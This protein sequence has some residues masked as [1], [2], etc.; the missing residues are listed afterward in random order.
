MRQHPVIGERIVSPLH[1][2]TSL[3]QVIRHHHERIDGAGYPD[4]LSGDEIPITARVVAVCDAHDA[5]ITD[6]PYRKRRSS[7]EAVAILRSGAGSQWDAQVVDLL[8]RELLGTI[9]A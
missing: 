1:S 5:L 7:D 8:M 6:R 2:G 4:G 9:P 3:L